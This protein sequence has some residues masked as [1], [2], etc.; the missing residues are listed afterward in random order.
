MGKKL[1]FLLTLP[2]ACFC[3]QQ[4]PWF[5]E[6]LE[7]Q[8]IP[9][10][11]FQHY[12]SVDRAIHPKKYHSNDQIAQ[13]ALEVSPYPTFDLQMRVQFAATHEKHFNFRDGGILIRT[14]LLNDVEGDPI[15]W[16][17]GITSDFVRHSFL[18]D[19]STPYHFV[20]NFELGSA[21]GKEITRECDWIARFWAYVGG[22]IANRGDPWTH[23]K[24]A[25]WGNFKNRHRLHLFTEA[26]L[27]FGRKNQVDISNHEGYGKIHHQSID[28]GLAYQYHF[29]IWGELTLE[30]FYRP[31][32]HAFP[33][34][35]QSIT[36]R[37]QL[38]FSLF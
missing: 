30:Y 10:Y 26:Y 7:F 3:Y 5:P 28:V 38:P 8:W 4:Q 14:L 1:L 15:S 12:P 37:Y 36:L 29:D 34:N 35:L 17:V 6:L 11:T 2:V 21:I 18:K 27:G 25:I 20:S 31:Y 32:A 19:V 22:G 13:L 33:K 23:A 9:S 16:T 24:L